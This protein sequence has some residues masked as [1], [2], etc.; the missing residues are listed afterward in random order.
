M[1]NVDCLEFGAPQFFPF[2]SVSSRRIKMIS[3][4]FLESTAMFF[5]FFV[6]KVP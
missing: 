4:N 6:F 5:S 3:Q 2:Y 1:A